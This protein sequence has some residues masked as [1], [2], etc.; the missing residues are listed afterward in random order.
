MEQNRPIGTT[1]RVTI[2][3]A[4]SVYGAAPNLCHR[5]DYAVTIRIAASVY[6]AWHSGYR[7]GFCHNP[8]RCERLWSRYP[9][10]KSFN[11]VTIRIAAS[12]YGALQLRMRQKGLVTIRIAASVY[13]AYDP[14]LMD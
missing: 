12:V 13:G 11:P 1:Q 2:R 14:V 10:G 5:G 9:Q 8:H 7:S 6:G 3:I 4:A